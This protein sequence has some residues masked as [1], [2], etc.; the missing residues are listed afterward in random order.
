MPVVLLRTSFEANSLSELPSRARG[1]KRPARG[2]GSL[3]S[4]GSL[5]R[6]A[7]AS[8]IPLFGAAQSSADPVV[9]AARKGKSRAIEV[10]GPTRAWVG[11]G[12][13]AQIDAQVLFGLGSLVLWWAVYREHC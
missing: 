7:R 2:P 6:L 12:K 8:G 9:S 13:L 11:C 1:L 3:S 4:P 10:H 5:P